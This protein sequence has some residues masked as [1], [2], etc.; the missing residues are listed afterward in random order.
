MKSFGLVVIFGL[1]IWSWTAF[2]GTH[3]GIT[4]Q[5]MVQIQNGLQDQ[6][7][8]VLSESSQ[9]L[10]NIVIKKFSTK[11]IS[12]EKVQ[13]NFLIAFDEESEGSINKI[14]RKGHVNLIKADDSKD[15][16]VWIVDSIKI[17]GESIEFEKGLKFNSSGEI[18]DE[19]VAESEA[20]VETAIQAPVKAEP[21]VKSKADVKQDAK[22][23]VKQEAKP[24]EVKPSEPAT[25]PKAE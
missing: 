13:A 14:E 4:E 12:S 11:E 15:E 3:K 16:Q 25:T 19:E 7:L 18:E 2:Y 23:D 6:I 24:E 8:K 10:N 5:T 21:K 22:Q 1:M 17:E 20:V 9:N